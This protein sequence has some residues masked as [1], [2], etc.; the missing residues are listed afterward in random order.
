M[1]GEREINKKSIVEAGDFPNGQIGRTVVIFLT[2][3]LDN[4]KVTAYIIKMRY[5]HGN[6][7]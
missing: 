5:L 6:I 1:E 4:T 2:A 3:R 7:N